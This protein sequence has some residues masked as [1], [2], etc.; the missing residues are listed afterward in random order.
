MLN[1]GRRPGFALTRRSCLD[2]YEQ[3]AYFLKKEFYEILSVLNL[4]NNPANP[5]L[6]QWEKSQ[7][8]T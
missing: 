7:R 4:A 2:Y 3:L 5:C 6:E 8:K 1:A